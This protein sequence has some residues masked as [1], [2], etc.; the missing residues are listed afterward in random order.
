MSS[1]IISVYIDCQFVVEKYS[2]NCDSHNTPILRAYLYEDRE[3][4]Q[5]D[6]NYST[7]LAYCATGYDSNSSPA[8]ITGTVSTSDNY[9]EYDLTQLVNS[10]SAS[11]F[12]SQVVL[13]NNA[14]GDNLQFVMGT[15]TINVLK[16]PLANIGA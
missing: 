6:S 10:N 15:G 7:K 14:A 13:F 3:R 9:V 5:P 2:V 8:T 12:Y 1:A 16:S 11:S 4:W